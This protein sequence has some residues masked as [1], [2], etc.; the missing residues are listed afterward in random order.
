MKTPLILI[1][2]DHQSDIFKI[3]EI[4][5]QEKVQFLVAGNRDEFL[6][7]ITNNPVNLIL[8]EQSAG[9]YNCMEGLEFIKSI[10]HKS[11]FVV[12][13]NGITDE[14]W[15]NLLRNGVNEVVSKK[16]PERLIF[17]VKSYLRES[18][19]KEEVNKSV[20]FLRYHDEQ[21][22][23]LLAL[24]NEGVILTDKSGMIQ[25]VNKKGCQ[26][27]GYREEELFGQNI[28][29]IFSGLASGIN[30]P[31]NLVNLT[32]ESSELE[33]IRKDNQRIWIRITGS[34]GFDQ[35]G[36]GELIYIFED[37]E[38]QKK[39]EHEVRKLSRA[40]D[41][42]PETIVITDTEGNIEYA[43]PVTFE[44][45]GYSR[46]ELIGA[47]TRIFSSRL[48]S[49]EEYREMWE[50]IKSG[51]VWKGEFQNKKKNGEIY[52]E[53]ATISPV[54]NNKNEITHFLAIKEDITEQ[55]KMT[56]ELI[57]AK[58]RAETNDRLKSAFL[59][60]ISHEIRT[61]MNGIFGFAGL[62]RT[63]DLS[64]ELKD[65]YISIIEQSGQ[66]MLNVIN[67][68]VDIS[69]IES[70]QVE[71]HVRESNLHR[72]LNDLVATFAPEAE[73][74]NLNL[75]LEI[76][77]P[78]ENFLI[79]TDEDKLH[80][81]LTNLLKNAIKFT[82]SGSIRFGYSKSGNKLR[83]FVSDTGVGIP[84]Q[85]LSYIF[86]RFRQGST[87][88]TRAYE[89]IGLG[90]PICKAFV[91]LLGGTIWVDSMPNMGST[92]YFELPLR[93]KEVITPRSV[94]AGQ[95][96]KSGNLKVLVVEDDPNSLMFMKTLLKLEGITVLD[97]NNGLKAIESVKNHPEIDLVLIDMKMPEMDGFEATSRIKQIRPE[98]PVIAQT[99]YAM[100]EDI[101]NAGKAGCDD[102]ITKPVKKNILIE[103]IRKLAP[104]S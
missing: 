29:D 87:S 22:R 58:E 51:K 52:W 75:S 92:F 24:M 98:L 41:Q 33:L 53:S 66:R 45:T 25:F 64:E 40:V 62:L 85:Q 73:K 96:S 3:K 72:L 47:H 69:L 77:W 103:K 15:M 78:N 46:Q 8:S 79:Q 101:E 97:A 4:L 91:E 12:V 56:R 65:K 90:L 13:S 55:R 23:K 60:N 88:L 1:V 39:A 99:A 89:G 5:K 17:V 48:K 32:E 70:G 35:S 61:P 68:I 59:A 67:D 43:N 18:E 57:Q 11:S 76:Q 63:P 6:H 80:Q 54:L 30:T 20:K 10:G 37:V 82:Q 9:D 94:I 74:K 49:P 14:I 104:S 44:K 36:N 93:E 50:T 100:K 19:L 84:E 31:D 102:F 38:R 95:G 81:V 83:F 71:I 34:S 42:S 26:L 86:E 27:S 28:S 7:C 2:D 16:M 21:L